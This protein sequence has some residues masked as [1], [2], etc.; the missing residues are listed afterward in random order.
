MITYA[1]SH[2]THALHVC[3]CLHACTHTDTYGSPNPTPV[4]LAS[5]RDT[6]DPV[7]DSHILSADLDPDVNKP[8]HCR[9]N[10]RHIGEDR[11][12]GMSPEEHEEKGEL[13]PL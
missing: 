2:T 3:A 13:R 12:T 5:G 6:P 10:K 9:S 7:L 4:S 1:H 8:E 11:K